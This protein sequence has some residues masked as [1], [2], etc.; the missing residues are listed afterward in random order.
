M[1]HHYLLGVEP[2]S[3]L[4]IHGYLMTKNPADIERVLSYMCNEAEK[5]ATQLGAYFLPICLS[6]QL[7][8]KSVKLVRSIATKRPAI[9]T[10]LARAKEFHFSAWTSVME[11]ADDERLWSLH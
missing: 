6:T 5:M 3:G 2:A 11:D 10:S 1:K 9:K 8:P 4:H 7:D